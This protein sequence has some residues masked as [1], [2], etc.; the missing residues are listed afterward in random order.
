MIPHQFNRVVTPKERRISNFLGLDTATESGEVDVRRSP[1]TQNMYTT[2][3]GLLSKRFGFKYVSDYKFVSVDTIYTFLNGAKTRRFNIVVAKSLYDYTWPDA[4]MVFCGDTL[5]SADFYVDESDPMKYGAGPTDIWEVTPGYKIHHL[6]QNQDAN[7]EFFYLT[8]GYFIIATYTSY[9]AFTMVDLATF[10]TTYTTYDN[11]TTLSTGYVYIPTTNINRAKTDTG[12]KY[13]EANILTPY[14]YNTFLGDGVNKS[15]PLDDKGSTNSVIS[16]WVYNDS[17][18]AWVAQPVTTYYT[19]SSTTHTVTFV[20]AP[21]APVDVG[22][23]NVKILFSTNKKVN[24]SALVSKTVEFFGLNGNKDTMFTAIGKKEY[25]GRFSGSMYFGEN[26]YFEN[27]SNVV[28]YSQFGNN[29]AVHLDKVNNSSTITM[30]TAGLDNN[31]DLTYT[32]EIGVSGV[33]VLSTNT[34]ANLRDEP[35]WLSESGVMALVSTDVQGFNSAQLRSFYVKGIT[36]TYAFVFDD[37]YFLSNGTDTLYMTDAN[38]KHSD[39]K[40]GTAQYEWYKWTGMGIVQALDVNGKLYFIN[41]EGE[42]YRLKSESDTYPYMDTVVYTDVP[43][44]NIPYSATHW[45]PMRGTTVPIGYLLYETT[46]TLGGGEWWYVCHTAFALPVGGDIYSYLANF[47]EVSAGG[48]RQT[49]VSGSVFKRG[50]KYYRALSDNTYIS[51]SYASYRATNAV[52]I[53]VSE[54]ILAGGFAHAPITCYWKTPMMNTDDI[55]AFKT[56]KNMWVRVGMAVGSTVKIYYSTKGLVKTYV[57]ASDDGQHTIIATNRSDR[58]FKSIQFEVKNDDGNAF[59]L[60]EIVF[61]YIT[62]RQIRG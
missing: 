17:T 14:R 51:Y 16:V 1:D 2:D 43:Y 41:N 32:N 12:V 23:D 11:T 36:G 22:V 25:F 7:K 30:R 50:T 33:G 31:G 6:P 60:I 28:G 4:Y 35:L 5:P 62:N 57:K 48:Y 13:E 47:T 53:D 24:Q 18:K 10:I 61:R 34:F 54:Y 38:S 55:T 59:S 9:W 8:S 52:E 3:F 42:L 58:K 45:Y 46:G 29:L 39:S 56:L 26:Q 19:Y 49:I 44:E 37:K 20:M 40:A 21:P 27:A 15:F